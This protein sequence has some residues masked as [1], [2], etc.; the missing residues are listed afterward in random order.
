MSNEIK[1]GKNEGRETVRRKSPWRF[2]FAACAALGTMELLGSFAAWLMY[3][4][5][6]D[7]LLTMGEAASVGII[8]G[9]DGPTAIFVATPGWTHYL[10]PCFLVVVGVWGFIRFSKCKQK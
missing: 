4:S 1:N 10:V 5:M 9:A 2:L 6:S 3:L 8:G 7:P